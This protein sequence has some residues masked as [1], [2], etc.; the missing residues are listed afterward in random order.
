MRDFETSKPSPY[1][2]P[3]LTRPLSDPCQSLTNW[4]FIIQMYVILRGPFSF[5]KPSNLCFL[6]GGTKIETGSHCVPQEFP[7]LPLSLW[8]FCLFLSSAKITC[9]TIFLSL[10]GFFSCLFVCSIQDLT[11]QPRLAQVRLGLALQ[12]TLALSSQCSLQFGLPH[13]GITADVCLYST[14]CSFLC[15]QFWGVGETRQVCYLSRIRKVM[16]PLATFPI[17]QPC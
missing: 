11:L 7:K 17:I 16:T 14:G 4:R 6:G 8:S 5:T 10:V 1:H 2:M 12:P 9:I 15:V 3:P 13:P